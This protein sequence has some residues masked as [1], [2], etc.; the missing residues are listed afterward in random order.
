MSQVLAN[1]LSE[2]ES[3]NSLDE[4]FT[5]Q[6]RIISRI[7]TITNPNG[8][9]N[10]HAPAPVVPESL[11]ETPTHRLVIPGVY[12]RTKEEVEAFSA[13]LK[14]MLPPQEQKNFGKRDFSHL[15][16]EGK[17]TSELLIEDR[18]DRF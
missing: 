6:E 16:F 15:V 2:V 5:L 17:S 7:R 18:E 9:G 11:E 13:S 1:L 4:L 8:N 10:G 14:A 12:Y 3:L